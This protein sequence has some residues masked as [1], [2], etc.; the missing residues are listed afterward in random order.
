MQNFAS[1]KRYEKN[2]VAEETR[3]VSRAYLAN[4]PL[5]EKVAACS[6]TVYLV[7]RVWNRV[8]GVKLVMRVE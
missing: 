8:T 4:H 2:R 1:T 7:D 6:M 3:T 5:I